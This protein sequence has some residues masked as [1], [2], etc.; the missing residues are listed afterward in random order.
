MILSV[1][2]H[3]DCMPLL[4]SR[5]ANAEN[6]YRLTKQGKGMVQAGIL[7]RSYPGP[8]NRIERHQPR[9]APG[10]YVKLAQD[11]ASPVW[12]AHLNESC[13][14]GRR[15]SWRNR[16]PGLGNSPGGITQG[17]QRCLR[18]VS[19]V[20]VATDSAWH[21]KRRHYCLFLQS[22]QHREG[23]YAV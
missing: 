13:H 21:Y 14:H 3:V 10:S 2:T 18:Y 8:I 20:V 15:S 23:P 9:P 7:A 22:C 17:D 4:G 12:F 11:F 6:V 19:F 1:L 16:K 5:N